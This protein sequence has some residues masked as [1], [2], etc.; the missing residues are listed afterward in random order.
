MAFNPCY[1]TLF[2]NG[3]QFISQYKD[4]EFF[5]D[6]YGWMKVINRYRG[7]KLGETQ[8][9]LKSRYVSSAYMLVDEDKGDDTSNPN[10]GISGASTVP[11]GTTFYAV[12]GYSP[13]DALLCITEDSAGFPRPL[14][15]TRVGA[16]SLSKSGLVLDSFDIHDYIDNIEKAQFIEFYD[17]K[18]STQRAVKEVDS[19]LVNTLLKN[20]AKQT[21]KTSTQDEYNK[22]YQKTDTIRNVLD[23]I[24]TIQLMTKD[25]VILNLGITNN[26]YVSILT[27]NATI[28]HPDTSVWQPVWEG[29]T[30][31]DFRSYMDKSGYYY[32]DG[33]GGYVPK[34]APYDA[35]KLVEEMERMKQESSEG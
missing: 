27:N 22:L 6:A 2:F 12:N 28:Y 13:S 18:W 34:S 32:H 10:W 23:G 25:K 14:F 30:L 16:E 11:V 29:L 1:E 21:P 9:A 17:I 15:F 31:Q 7:E 4:Y 24:H 35:P 20:M 33:V 3:N 19:S 26:G 8:Y 5:L